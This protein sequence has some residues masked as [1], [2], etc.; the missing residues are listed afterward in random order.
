MFLILIRVLT[1]QAQGNGIFELV[2]GGKRSMKGD[3]E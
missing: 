1:C 3:N 2:T